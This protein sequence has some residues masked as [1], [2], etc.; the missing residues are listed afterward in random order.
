MMVKKMSAETTRREPPAYLY[1]I[2]TRLS[3]RSAE[4]VR[5]GMRLPS[6]RRATAPVRV[7]RKKTTVQPESQEHPADIR[8][9]D[10][11]SRDTLPRLLRERSSFLFAFN[12]DDYDFDKG[13]K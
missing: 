8:K 10:F 1:G 3:T 9:N 11:A 12:D 6:S 5:G 13:S 7:R 2:V 4:T